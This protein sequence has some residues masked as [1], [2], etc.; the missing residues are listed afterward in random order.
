MKLRDKYFYKVIVILLG[1]IALLSLSGSSAVM[2]KHGKTTVTNN[3]SN[4]DEKYLVSS[5]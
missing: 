4:I 3:L 1:V 2:S 5:R